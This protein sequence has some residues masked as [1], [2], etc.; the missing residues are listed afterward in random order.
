MIIGVGVK[1][2]PQIERISGMPSNQLKQ[3]GGK[4][5]QEREEVIVHFAN[6]RLSVTKVFLARVR[7]LVAERG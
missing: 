6:D 1:E 5:V 3:E 2:Q 7:E 4:K